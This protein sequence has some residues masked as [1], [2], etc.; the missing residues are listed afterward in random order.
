VSVDFYARQERHRL[1]E[2]RRKLDLLE[3]QGAGRRLL[4]IGACSGVFLNEARKR[5]YEVTGIEPDRESCRRA[6][7]RYGIELVPVSIEDARFD[8]ESYDVV[9]SSH[10]F[11][12]L[13]DPLAAA[14]KVARW[15]RPGGFHLVEVPQEWQSFSGRRR[16]W[17]GMSPVERTFLS[18]HH[19]VFFSRSTIRLLMDLSGCRTEHV[20][21][22][23]YYR[24]AGP[25]AYLR[26]ALA[27]LLNP[28]FG[29]SG[30]IEALGRKRRA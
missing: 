23:Y 2:Y 5:G 9:F 19:P 13:P 26:A 16:R 1:Q 7:E 21:N 30:V 6:E 12:H 27:R 14:R 3:R 18:I 20:R 4:E 8:D 15:L 10:V 11:E 24:L 25:L 22:V 17:L 28:L 29:G